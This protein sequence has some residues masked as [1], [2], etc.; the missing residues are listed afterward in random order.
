MLW[1]LLELAFVYLL[2]L[3]YSYKLLKCV[4]T[5]ALS[6]YVNLIFLLLSFSRILTF[7]SFSGNKEVQKLSILSIIYKIIVINVL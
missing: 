6:N 3:C 4:K 2:V 1:N 5:L 7:L